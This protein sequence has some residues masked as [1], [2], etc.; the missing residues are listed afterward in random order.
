MLMRCDNTLQSIAKEFVSRFIEEF[1]SEIGR[2]SLI[3]F[4]KFRSKTGR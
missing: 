4:E 2:Q 3:I 1:R